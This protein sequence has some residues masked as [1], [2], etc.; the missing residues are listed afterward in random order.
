VS[1]KK[2]KSVSLDPNK[3]FLNH[4]PIAPKELY[5]IFTLDLL[6]DEDGENLYFAD[7]D[8]FTQHDKKPYILD[9]KIG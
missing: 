5:N 6:A 1:S 7:L 4:D 2:K 3:A 8:F 9:H